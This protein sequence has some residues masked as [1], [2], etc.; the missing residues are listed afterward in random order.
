MGGAPSGALVPQVAP[1]HNTGDEGETDSGKDQANHPIRM[2]PLSSV[3]TYRKLSQ[4]LLAFPRNLAA[5]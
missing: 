5:T 3:P 4:H 1:D 2:T